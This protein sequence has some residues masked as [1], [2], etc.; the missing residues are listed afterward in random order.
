VLSDIPAQTDDRVL[1]DFRTSDDAGVYRWAGGP[2]L[3][4]TVDFFTP[5][6]DDPYTYGQ[7][8]AAN[9]ISDIY[10]MGG[11]PLTALAIAAFPKE[12]L[13][14]GT[15]KAIFQGGFDKLREAGVALLGG[16]TVADPEIKFGYAV[17]G[18]IDPDRVWS[19][20]GARPG[21]V[22][23]LTKP[24]GTGIVGTAIKFERAP[25]ALATEAVQ[26]M[27][28]LNRA[29]ADVLTALPAGAV[30]ACTDVT[31]FGLAGHGTEMARASGVTLAIEA[32]EIP[33][34]AGVLDIA[35]Q[36]R[37]GGL[38]SNQKH[39]AAGV[40]LASRTHL[41][42]GGAAPRAAR[43]PAGKARRPRIS[44][45]FEGG[46]TSPDGMHRGPNAGPIYE[47]GSS[48]DP[49][50]LLAYDPQTSGGLLVAVSAAAADEA[51]AGLL[52]AGVFHR[53][54]GR[55]VAAVPGVHILLVP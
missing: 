26:S 32:R 54:I 29:A 6:V 45:I 38:A 27:R 28:T 39:F 5:I 34:F 49:V 23:F 20:A 24:L 41:I 12:G 8:A 46:A 52:S 14:P 7:I 19:N 44:A 51:A 9:A 21:D 30:H 4:Q 35:E 25:S 47:M 36:N 42:N 13:D 43:R 53:R 3:V 2:A 17:T 40:R 16:H 55:V 37:S 15:I 48:P 50:E 18:A 31:G 22:L 10:A 1:V 11:R 33:V